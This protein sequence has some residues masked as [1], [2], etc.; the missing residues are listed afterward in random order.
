MITVNAR[1]GL[2]SRPANEQLLSLRGQVIQV[3]V[4]TAVSIIAP[5]DSRSADSRSEL[6]RGATR[7]LRTR[8]CCQVVEEYLVVSSHSLNICDQVAVNV[9]RILI[10]LAL[11]KGECRTLG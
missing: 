3:K 11:R 5:H 7:Q 8:V 2:V 6:T 10:I 1:Q 4:Q 9:R